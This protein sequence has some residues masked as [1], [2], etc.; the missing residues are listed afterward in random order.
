MSSIER[1]NSRHHC[2]EPAIPTD[3]GASAAL[4]KLPARGPVDGQQLFE[5]IHE[6]TRDADGQAAGLEFTQIKEW[7]QANWDRLTPEAKKIFET[8]ERE[9]TRSMQNGSTG[10]EPGRYDRMIDDMRRDLRC[11][12]PPPPRCGTPEPP[13]A[14]RHP[15]PGHGPGHDRP[16]RPDRGDRPV[17]ASAGQ[18]IRDLERHERAEARRHPCGPGSSVSGREMMNTILDGISDRDNQAASTEYHDFKNWANA[19]RDH[20]TPGAKR[21]LEVYDEYARRAQ[22]EGRTGLTDAEVAAMKR[23]MADAARPRIGDVPRERHVAYRG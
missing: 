20:L 13:P 11:S 16:G 23:E 19:N 12:P 15:H 18:A 9:A 3:S 1:T 21:V 7:A 10:I 8:Y 17:D 2:E 4:A 6:G 14:H 22:A 5:A